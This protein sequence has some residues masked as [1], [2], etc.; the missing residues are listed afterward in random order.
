MST[1]WPIPIVSRTLRG[2]HHS[3][4]LG[5][6]CWR[7]RQYQ[8]QGHQG[9]QQWRRAIR[10]VVY[11]DRKYIRNRSGWRIRSEKCVNWGKTRWKNY[12]EQSKTRWK[13][14]DSYLRKTRN[15]STAKLSQAE[16]MKPIWAPSS[17][18]KMPV[19]SAAVTIPIS[20]ASR[21]KAMPRTTCLKFIRQI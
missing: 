20:P 17:G 9:S 1:G 6:S 3:L 15:S 5:L 19:L 11:L 21:W 4:H 2:C 7:C 10:I 13:N 18:W 12:G 14:Y 16:G 8:S